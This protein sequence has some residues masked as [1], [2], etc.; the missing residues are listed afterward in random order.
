LNGNSL[1]PKPKLVNQ[2]LINECNTWSRLGVRGHFDGNNPWI[3]Y[4]DSITQSLTR[5]IGAKPEE[6]AVVGTLTANLHFVFVSFYRPTP[7]RYKIIRLAGFPSD[8]YAIQSQV[9]QRLETLREFIGSEPFK[10]KD[11]VI[12][13]KPDANGYIDMA[14]FKKV[15][16]E[17]G[18]STA[19]VWLEAV[20]YLTGQYFNI[21]ELVQLA[22]AK[23][24]KFG[25]D[26]A[27]GIGNVPLALHDW[28]VD[29]AVW[30]TYKY[31]SS[32]PGGIAGLYIHN[33]YF[34]DHAMM[35]FAGWWGNN[36]FTRFQMLDTFDP[37][38][39]A[40]GW[41]VSN[42]SILLLVALRASLAIFDQVDL[43]KLREKNIRLV[44]YLEKLL[45]Q[46]L[47]NNIQIITPKNQEERGCQL[48]LRLNHADKK[49]DMEIMFHEHGV[50]CDARR[51][52]IR[53][54]PMG[55]YNTYEDVYKFVQTAKVIC[56]SLH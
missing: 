39:T 9:Q 30:C 1:G 48:S 51:D 4:N 21:P 42:P 34:T 33:K 41:Q 14:T 45:Q 11:A 18:D 54:A 3:S 23:G 13:I 22:H 6:I 46:E 49:I 8:T 15:L 56:E 26:L 31:L 38:P 53:V 55:L 5:L 43:Q 16:D 17:H 20:H 40:E 47:S 32:S 29:F 50:I 2:A 24:C 12:E 7:K 44:N 27:H 37:M 10:L 52:L 19:I 36:K 25:L 28:K 35:R